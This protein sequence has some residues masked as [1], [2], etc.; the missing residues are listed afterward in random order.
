MNLNDMFGLDGRVFVGVGDGQI[1]CAGLQHVDQVL[2]EVLS[3]L[4][5]R[6]VRAQRRSL[7]PQQAARIV[8]ARQHAVGRRVV[9]E[10]GA[11]DQR[12]QA[13]AQRQRAQGQTS[14]LI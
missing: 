13:E 11:R 12:R 1:G 7:R 5:D 6:E 10:V 8:Q 14:R 2:R 3:D 4:H 9:D